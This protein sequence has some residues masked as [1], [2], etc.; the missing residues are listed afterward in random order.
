V[1][2]VRARPTP[3]LRLVPK[4]AEAP[5]APPLPALPDDAEI[6]ERVRRGDASVAPWLYRR[7]RPTVD[8]TILRI[9]GRRDNDHEDLVQVTMLGLIGSLSSFRGECSLDT[10]I[11]RL[12]AHTVFKELR[13]RKSERRIFELPKDEA[14]EG[15]H[16]DVGRGLV[17][18]SLVGRLRVH[19]EA[20][21]ALKATAVLLHDV[22]GYDLREVAQI[23]ESTVAAA[24]S[25]L[26]RGRAD[27]HARVCADP[28]L[29]GLLEG[30]QGTR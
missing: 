10:W 25:R 23:T 6:L 21:D 19:L 24:Q 2:P 3:V 4:E 5:V 28:A 26:V 30:R 1:L 7:A 14:A 15:S 20:M 11:S 8:R 16:D 13:R 12:T 27:L 22:C 29:A 17:A 9:L 18:R